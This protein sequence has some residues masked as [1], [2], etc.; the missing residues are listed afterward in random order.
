[1]V[2]GTAAEH[3]HHFLRTLANEVQ[4]VEQTI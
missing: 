2:D 1:V 4:Q 3:P